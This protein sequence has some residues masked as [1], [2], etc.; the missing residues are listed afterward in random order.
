MAG[1]TGSVRGWLRGFLASNK[2]AINGRYACMRALGLERRL[3]SYLPLHLVCN[4]I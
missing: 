1:G 4:C 2:Q 3:A